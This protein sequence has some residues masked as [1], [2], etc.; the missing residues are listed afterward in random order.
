MIFVLVAQISKDEW[1]STQAAVGILQLPVRLAAITAGSSLQDVERLWPEMLTSF[2]FG[3]L[4]LILGNRSAPYVSESVF[5]ELILSFLLLGGLTML[6]A[7]TGK[8]TVA[9]LVVACIMA[10]GLAQCSTASHSDSEEGSFTSPMLSD[11][12]Q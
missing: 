9:V 1:R 2:A 7:E 5:R 11:V 10:V 3:L 4:G 12:E 8:V 6:T